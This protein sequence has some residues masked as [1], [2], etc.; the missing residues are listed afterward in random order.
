VNLLT[1]PATLRSL[2]W[3]EEGAVVTLAE[4]VQTLASELLLVRMEAMGRIAMGKA[5]HVDLPRFLWRA[6]HDPESNLDEREAQELVQLAELCD[7]WWVFGPD[8]GLELMP[9][10]EWLDRVRS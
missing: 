7:G 4:D 8:E 10:S 9:L 3:H 5:R 1:D 6:A 2:S